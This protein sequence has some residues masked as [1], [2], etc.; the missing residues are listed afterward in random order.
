MKHLV[1]AA[2]AALLAFAPNLRAQNP[3]LCSPAE[4]QECLN[5]VSASAT[6]LNALRAG[7]TGANTLREDEE[8]ARRKQALLQPAR[9]ATSGDLAG[10]AGAAG[11]GWGVW[12][13]YGYSDYES[14]VAVAPYEADQN[15]FRVGVDKLLGRNWVVGVALAWDDTD[16]TTRFN[17]GGQE[18]DGWW[19]APYVSWIANDHVSV[20][21]NG[22]WGNAD[23]D[24]F[25]I[26]PASAPGAPL[27]LR[28]SFDSD[29][30]FW[31][32]AVNGLHYAGP[33]TLGGRV[34]YLDARETQD[35]YTEFGGPSVR[36]VRDRVVKLKQYFV[37][38]S[39][40]FPFAA[41]WEAYVS[42]AWWRDSS[43]DDGGTAGGL[44]NAVGNITPDDRDEWQWRFGVRF[45]SR[46][47]FTASAEYLNVS[48]RE[49][50][51]LDALTLLA[52]FDF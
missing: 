16:T 2:A 4:P 36:T 9:V 30:Q 24:Q 19:V 15:A 20:D 37:E 1:L 33:L 35:G 29:R 52:R 48:G 11:S 45:F 49:K 32:L 22:A 23:N 50:F 12:A 8:V 41:G 26:D 17:G 44:P 5:G 31:S 3:L 46:G 47:G 39:A 14:K 40:A 25:R 28:S 43:R 42:G 51:D 13:S 7:V 34:G 18:T 21:L 6:A 10:I 27:I 38:A